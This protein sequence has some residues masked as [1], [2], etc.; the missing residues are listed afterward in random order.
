MEIFE[1][2]DRKKNQ[3]KVTETNDVLASRSSGF[4]QSW[5]KKNLMYLAHEVFFSEIG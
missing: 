5:A 4:L 3:Q 2:A 1:N